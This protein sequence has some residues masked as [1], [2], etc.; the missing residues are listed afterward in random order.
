MNINAFVIK[1]MQKEYSLGRYATRSIKDSC[2]YDDVEKFI[3]KH[4]CCLN[5]L[6]DKLLDNHFEAIRYPDPEYPM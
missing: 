1:S 5:S 3:A 2:L 6:V 4:D